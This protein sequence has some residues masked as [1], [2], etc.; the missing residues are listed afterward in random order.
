MKGDSIPTEGFSNQTKLKDRVFFI[1]EKLSNNKELSAEKVL[2][3]YDEAIRI[4]E[5]KKELELFKEIIISGMRA[6]SRTGQYMRFI[7]EAEKLLDLSEKTN[8]LHRKAE[9]LNKISRVNWQLGNLDKALIYSQQSLELYESIGNLQRVTGA[10]GNL[11]ILYSEFGDYE[12]GLESFMKSA[13]L[14][15]KAG[16]KKTTAL[17]LNNVGITLAKLGKA[18]ES[19][20]YFE[21]SLKLKKELGLKEEIVNA[22]KNIGDT[23]LALKDI[24]KARS[25][26][27][28]AD[29]GAK[30]CND[31]MLL[32]E[33]SDRLGRFY[34]ITGDYEKAIDYLKKAF[35]IATKMKSRQIMSRLSEALAESC[36]KSGDFVD[37]LYFSKEYARL[38]KEIFSENSAK[39]IAELRVGFEEKLRLKEI[40]VSR[41]ELTEQNETLKKQ[42]IKDSLTGLYNR[43]NMYEDLEKEINLAK[44]NKKPLT[45]AM[46]DLDGFKMFND[47]NG[48]Q[49][50][51][52]LLKKIGDII[53]MSLRE[54][55]ISYRYG[56]EEF[57]IVLSATNLVGG[58]RVIDR[59]RNCIETLGK[60]F[61]P[62]VTVSAGVTQWKEQNSFEFIR[63][64]D[65]LLYIAK[66][67]GKNC[68]EVG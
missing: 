35:E 18:E 34:N 16:D 52:D 30:E 55:D 64:A 10:L 27:L 46:L 59:I 23:Y 1:S 44:E 40:E 32:L 37:A 50:G 68:I 21:E 13:K 39:K 6:L 60:Q 2:S 41:K 17:Q 47:I 56:G 15:E 9:T 63:E 43:K 57:M 14:S 36:E 42:I 26:L 66:S 22:L 4:C 11:G 58:E 12:K 20:G 31:A 62:A 3:L 29:K 61:T 24:D 67:K 54:T 33:S 45:L 19:L 53:R 7:E 48:H 65:R 28:E 51:D 8:D 38:Q 25:Y 5:E 49:N